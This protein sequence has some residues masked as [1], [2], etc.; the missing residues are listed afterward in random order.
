M[1]DFSLKI[2]YEAI[3]RKFE[4]HLDSSPEILKA[5]ENLAQKNFKRI[6]TALLRDFNNHPITQELKAGPE[7]SNI[8]N[9]LE[10]SGNLF[11]FLGF[12]NTEVPTLQLENL[13]EDI[14]I[15]RTV[16]RKNIFYFKILNVPDKGSIAGA[17]QMTW[18]SGTSWAYAV[19]NGEFNGDAELS[20]FIFKTYGGSRSKEGFQIQE[21]YSEDQF[22]PKSYMTE[23]L[24]KFKDRVN[25]IG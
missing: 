20:H 14:S 2:D 4:L 9:T 24:S 23:I 16:R 6:H 7:S 19:E 1:A 10:G 3:K 13:L 22:Q 21:E 15:K 18:G 8:S 11:A 17:T 12:Y 25:N 5:V